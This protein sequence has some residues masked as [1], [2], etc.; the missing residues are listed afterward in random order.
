MNQILEKVKTMV[1]S[2]DAEMRNLGIVMLQ[3]YIK[4]KSM[5][6]RYRAYIYSLP[7]KGKEK[8]ELKRIAIEKSLKKWTEKQ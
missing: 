8:K 7:L 6:K 5:Y 1:N 4:S 2:R 3:D